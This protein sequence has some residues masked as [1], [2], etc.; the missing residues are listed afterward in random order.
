MDRSVAMGAPMLTQPSSWTCHKVWNG[1][2]FTHC[3]QS[4]YLQTYP[5]FLVFV[6]IVWF[7]TKYVSKCY[8]KPPP[9]LSVSALRSTTMSPEFS[10]LE[11]TVILDSL[12]S[13]L[14]P[15]Y[16]ASD[17]SSTEEPLD[18]KNAEDLV[19][20]WRSRRTRSEDFWQN[21]RFWVGIVGGILWFEV[22]I[23]KAARQG[24]WLE[25]IFPGWITLM[26]ALHRPIIPILTMHLPV[27][28]LLFRS[29]VIRQSA[30]ALSATC[31]AAELFYWFALISIPYEHKLDRL[32]EGGTSKGGGTLGSFGHSLP[33]HPEEPTSP[34]S[35][36]TYTFLL[37]LLFKHY[38]NPITVADIPGIREDDSSAAALGAFRAYQG[39]LDR[40]YSDKHGQKRKRDLGIDLLWFFA[41]ELFVQAGWGII[42]IV[43]EYLPPT[44]LRLLLEYVN[45][46][47]KEPQSPSVAA[48][49]VAMMAI[50]Q[51]F[52]AMAMGQCLLLGRRL[53]IRLRAI[54][55]AEVFAKALRRKDVSGKTTKKDLSDGKEKDEGTASEGKI[56][57]LVSV[58]AFTISEICAYIFY[59]FSCPLSVI[60]NCVLLYMA[61]GV[62]SFAGIA[63]LVLLMPLQGLI[64]KLYTR[65]QNVFMAATDKRLESVT[66]VIAYIKL[67]KFNAWEGKFYERLDKTRKAELQALGYRFMVTILFQLLVWGTPVL[68]TGVAF[69]VHSLVLKQHLSAD[70]AFASLVL[71]NMMKDPLA[72]FQNT[73]TRLLQAYTSCRR[74][75]EYLEEPD[76][77]KY[78]QISKP[79]PGD[80]QIGFK[81]AILTY[82]ATEDIQDSESDI[83]LFAVGELNIEFPVGALSIISGH[84]GSGKTTLIQGLLGECALFQ[85]QV[86]M[87]DDHANRATC[88]VDPTTS[89]SDTVAY[90]AQTPWLVGTSIRENIIFGARW[91]ASRYR[92]VVDACA[93]RTDFDM[94]EDGDRTEVG[95]K[96]TTCSGGQKARIALARAIYSPAKTVILDDVLSAVDAQ[97]AR[98]LYEHVLQG[99]LTEG[100]TV[101]MVTH[102]VG[103]VAKAADLVIVLEEGAVIGQGSVDDL[104][105]EGLLDIDDEKSS[106]AAADETSVDFISTSSRTLVADD[107]STV[108][109]D[110]QG[111]DVTLTVQPEPTASVATSDGKVQDRSE[112]VKEQ[113]QHKLVEAESQAH[114]TIGVSTYMLY[115]KSMGGLVFWVL[116][117]SAFVGSNALQVGSNAWVKRW[118]NADDEATVS[119]LMTSTAQHVVSSIASHSSKGISRLAQHSTMYY[120]TIYWGISLI[121]LLAVAARVGI[122]FVGA[123]NAS[124]KIYDRLLN[125]IMGAK[126]RF[127]D[128]TPSGRIMNRLSKDMSAIDQE[129][130]EILMYFANCCLSALTVLVVV[131]IATPAFI[132]ALVLILF[133]YWIIGSF[134]VTTNREIKRIDSVTRSPILISFSEALV[135]M[136]TI[137]SYGDSA[138]FLRKIFHELDQ[139]TRCFWY[140]WQINLVLHIFSNLVG[141]LVTI[142]A[143]I[144]A[145]RNPTMDAGAVGLSISYAL[146]FTEYI[147]WVV[148][149]YASS[150][151]SMNSVERVGEYLDLEVEEEEEEKGVEPPAYWPSRDGSVIIENLT[152]SYAPHLDPVLKDVS[153][154]I[155]PREK[156]GVCGRTGCGK[157]TLALS[158][159]RFLHQSEG[160]II[161]DGQDISKLSLSALRS[162]LTILP[163]EAQ[164]FSGTIRDNLDPFHQHE[165]HEIWDALSQ[166][167]MV[168]RSR[169]PSRSHSRRQSRVSLRTSAGALGDTYIGVEDTGR[170]IRKQPSA[171]SLLK[172]ASRKLE[173]MQE[174]DDEDEEEDMVVIRS[175]GEGVAAGGKNFSQGQRQLLALARGLLKLK[176]S[177]FL[178][179]D[180]STANLDQETDATIQDVLRTGLRDTQMLVIAHRLM[181]VCGLD[182]ILV[183]DSGREVEFGT[184]WELLK[185]EG[186]GAVFK[187]LCKQSGNERALYEVSLCLTMT[188]HE[189]DE[190]V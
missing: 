173:V 73:F 67:I 42:C 36:A 165:D 178:I 114:G 102:Q 151:M 187:G 37:P 161:I 123:L 176:S 158:F 179:M 127:F 69:A 92:A 80:P 74:I 156:I 13:N 95:E 23:A 29:T 124:N 154:T 35:R 190:T 111:H 70:R 40:Q 88:P 8:F 150:E 116:L 98:H 97:T 33:S 166:C 188:R 138:R 12:A 94:F 9:S 175:L 30:S 85:G 34:F 103:L 20:D 163:Q 180:E 121:Y 1:H 7:A 164:L 117:V 75:Q 132:G 60:V 101:I 146:S 140:M 4:R 25:L 2:D 63:V 147:L 186:E 157:S 139:N 144:F 50:G 24:T 110:L 106:V 104:V 39:R 155:G 44:G 96:G 181:T 93:L 170:A 83:D 68:V 28:L 143:A 189:A 113:A 136:S 72:L 6:S 71:F 32:L 76:T 53:C 107:C 48:L 109:V 168:T 81:G 57:N 128:S 137:R 66:E 105:A 172:R 142:F 64:G 56:N 160:R 134:Y 112:E 130:G 54:I 153:F 82:A 167:G 55:V 118:A 135:G 89:L 17:P 183:L 99:P 159:F 149:M 38:K 65:Y 115:F 27:T 120:L 125:R 108:Q 49:Y 61:L 87:P 174:W 84:V 162:R 62:A 51:C 133:L 18:E 141:A 77:L 47:A 119:S 5:I 79:G 41:P 90:C 3:F 19:R 100:R 11:S 59:L 22:E 43:F 182:K 78:Q 10:T 15:P 177:C 26:S 45:S 21:V 31:I 52:S 86:F 169:A 14:L 145:L 129:A 46:R 184:P 185:K 91:D 16:P 152:C 131:S 126:M 148:R 122:T 58:D 171:R